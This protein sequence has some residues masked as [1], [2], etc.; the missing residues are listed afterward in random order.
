MQSWI[1]LVALIGKSAAEDL[2]NE[3][4]PTVEGTR[5]S[6]KEEFKSSIPPHRRNPKLYF[7][8]K[9]SQCNDGMW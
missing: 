4:T 2:K 8:V 9:F 5:I 7:G 1:F 3:D 6:E